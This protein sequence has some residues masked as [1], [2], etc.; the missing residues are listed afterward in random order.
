MSMLHIDTDSIE[1]FFVQ[2][3]NERL[4]ETR[5]R[6]IINT[7]HRERGGS[8]RHNSL[9][10]R[11]IGRTEQWDVTVRLFDFHAKRLGFK[12]HERPAV[13]ETPKDPAQPSLF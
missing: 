8:L 9:A 6:K 5:V 2:K 10:E 3:M 7:M 4:P 12:Q 1:Q 11:S 13:E